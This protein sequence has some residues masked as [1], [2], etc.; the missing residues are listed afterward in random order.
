MK[1]KR[2]YQGH[3]KNRHLDKN[4]CVYQKTEHSSPTSGNPQKPI[5][6]SQ[7]P[8]IH[9]LVVRSSKNCKSLQPPSGP[10]LFYT[11]HSRDPTP[12]PHRF[13]TNQSCTHFDRLSL[14]V[15]NFLYLSSRKHVPFS[16]S[17]IPT[18]SPSHIHPNVS[19]PSVRPVDLSSLRHSSPPLWGPNTGPLLSHGS[20]RCDSLPRHTVFT[21]NIRTTISPFSDF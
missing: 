10:R 20:H 7:Y 2:I 12:D 21:D 14:Q 1:F 16:G 11:L 18:G 17:Q 6:L 9:L 3:D 13:P 19:H 15:R 8:S 5:Y 4:E